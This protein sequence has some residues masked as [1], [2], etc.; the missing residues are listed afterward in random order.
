M[1][2]K[3]IG[4]LGFLAGA[5]NY[6]EVKKLRKINE[7]HTKIMLQLKRQK[8]AQQITEAQKKEYQQFLRNTYFEVRSK[9]TE[10]LAFNDN[11]SKFVYL[12]R[13]W[14]DVIQL[15]FLSPNEFESLQ[16]KEYGLETIR[17]Y[18]DNLDNI[19]DKFTE[20]EKKDFEFLNSLNDTKDELKSEMK[21][22]EKSFKK[23][24]SELSSSFSK[25]E[26][27]K[28]KLKNNNAKLSELLNKESKSSFWGKLG[29]KINDKRQSSLSENNSNLE[30][31]IEELENTVIPHLN[32]ETEPKQSLFRDAKD[33]Y[34]S[35]NNEI[36]EF[37]V[38]YPK[39]D[40]LRGFWSS[41][42]NRGINM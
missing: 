23:N 37:F 42:F 28:E 29:T 1:N 27:S 20:E 2:L 18:D 13:L 24:Q 19:I 31:L 17:L 25:L 15:A 33:K 38:K 21:E 36:E 4:G 30:K 3:T 5:G 35:F 32:S 41:M 8:A 40:F 9:I 10:I 12:K 6:L 7:Q 34:D 39:L 26:K 22:K 11:I 16:D 14:K